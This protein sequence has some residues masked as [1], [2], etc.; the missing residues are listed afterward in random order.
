MCNVM[1][2][3]WRRW[4]VDVR[5]LTAELLVFF[6]GELFWH[7]AVFEP[8]VVDVGGERIEYEEE[9]IAVLFNDKQ[10][11]H[12]LS[13]LLPPNVGAGWFTTAMKGRKWNEVAERRL[14]GNT[15]ALLFPVS[16]KLLIGRARQEE[17]LQSHFE[18]KLFR[19]SPRITNH[20]MIIC[21]NLNFKTSGD[22][23]VNL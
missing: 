12:S 9:R 16:R 5:P 4:Y 21:F 1:T 22:G 14:E 2:A 15:C 8:F 19:K 13:L 20:R 23:S 6:R 7:F 3:S 11:S 10:F 18:G 17:Y